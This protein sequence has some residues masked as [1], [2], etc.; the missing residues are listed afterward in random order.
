MLRSDIAYY[1]LLYFFE[2]SVKAL[3]ATQQPCELPGAPIDLN[4]LH[5]VIAGIHMSWP[6]VTEIQKLGVGV[7][8]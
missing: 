5:K 1:F 2:E 4:A 6:D 7:K 3:M 8:I